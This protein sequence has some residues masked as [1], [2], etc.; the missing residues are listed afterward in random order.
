MN[1]RD[2]LE[3]PTNAFLYNYGSAA[4]LDRLHNVL[5]NHRLYFSNPSEFQDPL[6]ARPPFKV[7]SRAGMWRWTVRDY[8]MRH[9]GQPLHAAAKTLA[10]VGAFMERLSPVEIAAMFQKEFHAEMERHRIYCLT[11]RADNEHLWTEYAAGHTGYCLQFRNA[12]LFAGAF[13]VRY[14][15]QS[16]L[17][18][19]APGGLFLVGKDAEVSGR[20]GGQ[21]TAATQGAAGPRSI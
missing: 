19:L 8:N 10:E 14:G 18:P 20:R 21:D 1:L 6:D 4:Y 9:H 2:L 16:E 15:Q 7:L 5:F 12:G 13:R 11:T 17:D 3:R